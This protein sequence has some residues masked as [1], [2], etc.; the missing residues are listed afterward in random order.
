M[1]TANLELPRT[2]RML[3]WSAT[4]ICLNI[5]AGYWHVVNSQTIDKSVVR[6]RISRIMRD[7]RK[8]GE[9][10]IDGVRIFVRVSPSREDVEELKKYG[11]EAVPILTEYFDS[12]DPPERTLALRLLGSLGGSRIV[13]PLR[14]VILHHP[15]ADFRQLALNWATQAPW[16]QMRPIVQMAAKSDPNPQVRKTAREVLKNLGSR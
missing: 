7:I 11:D 6:E 3:L 15:S 16:D 9:R 10:E 2:Q 12:E 13:Q 1:K 4:I 5:A 8:K 14:K